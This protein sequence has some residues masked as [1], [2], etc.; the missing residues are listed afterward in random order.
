M[1]K[2]K[3]ITIKDGDN[4]LRFKIRQMSSTDT[5]DWVMRVAQ[6]A[7]SADLGDRLGLARLHLLLG[8]LDELVELRVVE[9]YV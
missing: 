4:D 7:A 8:E 2:S 9:V 6:L 3:I 1:I 5:E